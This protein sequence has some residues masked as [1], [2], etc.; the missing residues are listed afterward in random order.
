MRSVLPLSLA[1]KAFL[2]S[3]YPNG[4]L[5]LW[6][7]LILWSGLAS[8]FP[9]NIYKGYQGCGSC[10]VSPHGGGVLN[11]YGRALE[12][13]FMSTF[14]K[15]G[16]NREFFV[17]ESDAIDVS[18]NY[19][20]LWL[21]TEFNEQSVQR[22]FPMRTALELA[23]HVDEKLSLVTGAGYYGRKKTPEYRRSYLMYRYNKNISFLSGKYFLPYGLNIQDHTSFIKSS[24]SFDQGDETWNSGLFFQGR[25]GELSLY[26]TMGQTAL[27]EGTEQGRFNLQDK[28]G[29][30]I[31]LRAAYYGGRRYQLGVS[32]LKRSHRKSYGI[33]ATA[34]IFEN[35]Y[36]LA[37]VDRDETE[38]SKGMLYYLKSG[39]YIIKGLDLN[40]T[41]ERA[42]QT[43]NLD[44]YR[45]GIDWSIVP[46]VRMK[47]E[48][49]QSFLEG[50]Q[51]SSTYLSMLSL[52]I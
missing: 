24:L 7:S 47:H 11:D 15:E 12:E 40:L 14:I 46:R 32:A 39:Y 5:P 41:I 23:W 43:A 26:Y 28:S 1:I 44:Q 2:K 10:H 45:L 3:F 21:S 31:A 8:A 48:F 22:N 38:D 25:R 51:Q 9:R 19:D 6:L 42:D 20:Y 36:L 17:T 30:G 50:R 4:T 29:E 52:S 34:K 27:I 37:E 16:T 35:S 33:F 18:F 13:E 49:S